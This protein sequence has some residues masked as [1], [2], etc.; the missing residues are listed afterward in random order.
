MRAARLAVTGTMGSIRDGRPPFS[1]IDDHGSIG[2]GGDVAPVVLGN[3]IFSV[4]NQSQI[5]GITDL[6][7]SANLSSPIVSAGTIKAPNVGASLTWVDGI[8]Q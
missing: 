1:G 6:K 2:G 8:H 3:F 4:R 5:T 7:A